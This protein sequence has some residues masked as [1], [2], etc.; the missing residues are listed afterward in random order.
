MP[1]NQILIVSIITV[2]IA[3]S[4]FT[5]L[6]LQKSNSNVKNNS[7]TISSLLAN[8]KTNNSNQNISASS[9]V[10][11]QIT[12]SFYPVKFLVQSL[13]GS[14]YDV[15]SITPSNISPHEYESTLQ[16]QKKITDSKLFVYMG[17]GIDK[18]AD[19]ITQNNSN[20]SLAINKSIKLMEDT[21]DEDKK[22]EKPKTEEKTKIAGDISSGYDPHTWLDPKNMITASDAITSELIKLNP[23]KTSLFQ[24]NNVATKQK[25]SDLDSKFTAGLK[26]C[27]AG[28]V[29][30]S[31]DAF[32]YLAK[33]YGFD[34]E[35]VSGSDPKDQVSLQAFEKIKNKVIDQKIKFVFA[36][37]DENSKT[38]DS[39]ASKTN[40][41]VLELGTLETVEV[42]DDYFSIMNKNLDNLK[43][44]RECN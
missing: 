31:H 25:L 14:E 32:G 19:K 9:D 41:K 5:V 16:D 42:A 12:T 7:N 23:A 3:I 37:D 1:K 17:G 43:T 6:G 36:G 15:A 18:W 35:S 11:T 34:I 38:I 8:N 44:A 4:T 20:N 10:K 24:A 22:D 28:F 40:S 30:T 27:K 2:I 13:A 26:E 39:L 21:G 33:S 29:V